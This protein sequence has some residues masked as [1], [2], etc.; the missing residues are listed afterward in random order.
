MLTST[1]DDLV[2]DVVTY[3]QWLG[4]ANVKKAD[5]EVKEGGLLQEDIQVELNANDLLIIEVKGVHG[6]STDNECGQ[7]GKNVLR[8]MREHKYNN[9]YGLYIVNNEMGK[10]P[11]KR[12]FPP[13]N[14]TQIQ[15]A[16]NST[17]GL[18]YTYQLFN[19]YFEIESG[20]ITKEE[21]QKSLLDYGLVDFRKNFKSVGVPYSYFKQNTIICLE[22]QNTEIKIGDFFYFEDGRKRLQKVEIK[23][24]E[25]E[26]TP[27]SFVCNGKTGFGL[28]NA[29]PRG[30]EILIKKQ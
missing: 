25:Q 14:E 26:N 1:G 20:I 23:S 2:N 16:E 12:T 17:R 7:I 5:D 22:I 30:A 10:E 28:V 15:D 19:L 4:F 8:R 11:L 3:L 24:I 9:V 13:F 29:V 18:A 6:T 21:A 27:V